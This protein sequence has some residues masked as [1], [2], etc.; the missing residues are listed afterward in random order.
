MWKRVEY[1]GHFIDGYPAV[2]RLE[3]LVVGHGERV[4][5]GWDGLGIRVLQQGQTTRSP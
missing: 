4:E 5:N 1:D 3:D 2:G